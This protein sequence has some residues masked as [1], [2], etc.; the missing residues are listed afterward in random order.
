MKKP[1]KKPPPF[2][3][4]PYYPDWVK[5]SVSISPEIL[6]ECKRFSKEHTLRMSQLVNSALKV[7]ISE[8]DEYVEEQA[9]LKSD[10][11]KQGLTKP[12][13]TFRTTK[14]FTTADAVKD[15]RLRKERDKK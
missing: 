1:T 9:K 12:K 3:D 11:M 13:S 10:W 7:F 5:F 8:A 15:H 14:G 6:K 4:G 2:D